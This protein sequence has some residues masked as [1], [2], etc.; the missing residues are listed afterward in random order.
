MK[1]HEKQ[2]SGLGFIRERY[3][4]ETSTPKEVSWEGFA[5]SNIPCYISELLMYQT[6]VA[7][8]GLRPPNFI[9]IFSFIPQ[10]WQ[11]LQNP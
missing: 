5:I 6:V 3:I 7:Q 10:G 4:L 8:I 2:G 1:K 11:F 9:L